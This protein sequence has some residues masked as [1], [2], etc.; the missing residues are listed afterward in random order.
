MP[1]VPLMSD[2]ELWWDGTRSNL[3]AEMPEIT[4]ELDQGGGDLAIAE[5]Y[6]SLFS[7]VIGQARHTGPAA[8][9]ACSAA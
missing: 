7:T 6:N 3:Q 1:C 4:K 5:F 8:K 2:M 9:L